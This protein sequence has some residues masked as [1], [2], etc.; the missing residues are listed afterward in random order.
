MNRRAFV[1]ILLSL[2]T[3]TASASPVLAKDGGSGHSGGGSGDSGGDGGGNE[4]DGGGGD[5]GSGGGDDGNSGHNGGGD[6]QSGDGGG[7][8][9]GESG[10]GKGGSGSD[11]DEA[12]AAIDAKQALPLDQMLAIFR[13]RGS[14]TVLDVKLAHSNDSFL[15]VF[16]YID[17][18]GTVRKA[19]FNAKSGALIN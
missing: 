7:D 6:G 9:N 10:S 4:G 2:L 15:Y 14:Y 11:H 8:G 13:Q 17:D 18:A 1:I 16:K 12:K 5:S 3:A 19:F